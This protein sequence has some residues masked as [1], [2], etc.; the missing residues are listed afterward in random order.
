MPDRPIFTLLSLVYT[1]RYTYT[2]AIYTLT[3]IYTYIAAGA[4][5]S[6]FT[7]SGLK[8]LI[9]AHQGHVERYWPIMCMYSYVFVYVCM[10][11]RIACIKPQRLDVPMLRGSCRHVYVFVYECMYI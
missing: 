8:G 5:P 11:V 4:R 10:Y 9:S 2:H 3:H 6:N 7:L 1:P